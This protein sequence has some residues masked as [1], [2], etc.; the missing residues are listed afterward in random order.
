MESPTPLYFYDF[1]DFEYQETAA[2]FENVENDFCSYFFIGVS[3][4]RREIVFFT[5]I[6]SRNQQQKTKNIVNQ[7]ILEIRVSTNRAE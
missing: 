7:R 1:L 6:R 3:T 5:K 2:K 4:N